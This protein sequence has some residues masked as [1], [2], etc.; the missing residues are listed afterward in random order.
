MHILLLINLSVKWQDQNENIQGEEEGEEEGGGEHCLEVVAASEE[1][2]LQI[3]HILD[4]INSFTQQVLLS[5]YQPVFQILH[6]RFA[7]SSAVIRNKTRY[8]LS[9]VPMV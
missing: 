2:E 4:K 5:A 1:I 7:V 8:V 9:V 6:F 3:Q